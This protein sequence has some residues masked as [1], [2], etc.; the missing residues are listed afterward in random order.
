M[1]EFPNKYEMNKNWITWFTERVRTHYFSKTTAIIMFGL[2]F[3]D[4]KSGG[5]P[6]K[7]S[8]EGLPHEYL[9]KL[10]DL[11]YYVY[12]SL[13]TMIGPLKAIGIGIAFKNMAVVNKNLFGPEYV[14]TN[15]KGMTLYFERFDLDAKP[16]IY[17]LPDL[18]VKKRRKA[19]GDIGWGRFWDYAEKTVPDFGELLSSMGI[20]SSGE[21]STWE[22]HSSYTDFLQSARN[23]K[24]SDE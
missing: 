15:G 12:H 20:A 19:Y 5:F 18:T 17:W 10:K 23:D 2:M 4:D 9:V 22:G 21:P 8:I 6:Y 14:V 11:R 13:L 16:I 7:S 1:N 3:R 24:E